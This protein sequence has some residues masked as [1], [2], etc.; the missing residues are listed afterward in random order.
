LYANQIGVG[1]RAV[2]DND[3]DGM[4]DTV[5]TIAAAGGTGLAIHGDWL[6][7]DNGDV[8]VRH[9]LGFALLPA[10]TGDTVVQELPMQGD[11]TSHAFAINA[12]G[13]L[14][15]AI[16]SFSNQCEGRDPC[17]E[18]A[19]RAGVWRYSSTQT[20]QRAA[21]GARV[22]AGLRNAVGITVHRATQLLFA[23]QHGRDQLHQKYPSMFS[24]ESGAQNPAEEL[25]EIH[26]GDDFGWP[27][28]YH[29]FTA[30]TR[31]LGP[32]YGGDRVS[33]GRCAATRPARAAF[34]GHWAPNG[35]VFYEGQLFP[36]RYVGGAFVAFHGSW[37]RAPL[38]QAGFNVSFVRLGESLVTAHEVFADGF[39]G[40]GPIAN[41]ADALYRPAGV[42]VGPDG[43]LF[44]SDDS[45]GRIWRIIYR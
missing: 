44:V 41:P 35:I 28:C 26:D 3:G 45:R 43:S 30:G 29:D 25:L 12:R 14:L 2:R 42:A 37:N 10:L 13:D 34:P 24:A 9:R 40:P 4:A 7:V 32:E 21:D 39:A 16:G 11:H 17:P 20:R 6:F 23:M 33:R 38:A 5:A 19:T 18:L 15:V 1:I 22:A 27:Y 8:I 36:A 31:V